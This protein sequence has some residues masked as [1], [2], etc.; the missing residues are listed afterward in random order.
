MPPIQTIEIPVG[1]SATLP[2]F[3]LNPQSEF[4]FKEELST[5]EWTLPPKDLWNP[6]MTEAQLNQAYESVKS[7]IGLP[8]INVARKSKAKIKW[9]SRSRK[10]SSYK[11]I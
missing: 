9:T 10:I 3:H 5:R 11:P 2:F 7:D 6:N 8:S 4:F 1:C